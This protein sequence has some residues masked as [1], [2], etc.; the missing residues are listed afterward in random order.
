MSLRV[1]IA[2]TVYNGEQ[3]LYDQLQSISAQSR[4]VYELHATDDGSIDKSEEIFSRFV[5]ENNLTDSWHYHKNEKNLGYTEN[6]LHCADLC[7]GDVVFFSDQ[8][9]IWE[10]DKIEK[11]ITVL[12]Q[13]P[14]VEAVVCGYDPYS[15]G[16]VMRS[17]V[18][19]L[20]TMREKNG[21]V[22]F[23]VQVKDMLSGGLTLCVRKNVL[24]ELSDYIRRKGLVYDVPIGL[25][26]ASRRSLYRVNE[27]LVLHRI[28][29]LN[30]GDPVLT[31]E[32]RV[33]GK[34]RHI[35]GRQFELRNLEGVKEEC[36]KRLNRKEQEA[37]NREIEY[38]RRAI[39][40]MEQNNV[41]KL[42]I[43]IFRMGKY[44]NKFIDLAN[45]LCCLNR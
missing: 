1:S 17:T 32:G 41:M 25:I 40:N 26:C 23:P 24:L 5:E 11:M 34:Q 30:T 13:H 37:Y 19:K 35:K 10:T 9:D 12:E 33:H 42:F 20:K 15:N 44:D 3:Y 45:F 22:P 43:S 39:Q 6:F 21:I 28:H 16:H 14:E 29:A 27:K 4:N 8:D 7:E 38:R 36:F 18:E 31:M 2:M